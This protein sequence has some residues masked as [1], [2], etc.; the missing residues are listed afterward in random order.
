MKKTL[1]F[2]LVM[3]MGMMAMSPATAWAEDVATLNVSGHTVSYD[4]LVNAVHAASIESNAEN[5]AT[6]TVLADVSSTEN[7]QYFLQVPSGVVTLD[8]NGHTLSMTSNQSVLAVTGGDLTIVDN[9]ANKT[10]KL[11][12]NY[13]AL[14]F[15]MGKLTVCGG[16][17]EGNY[18]LSAATWGIP[19]PG[20]IALRGGTFIKGQYES[21]IQVPYFTSSHWEILDM[22][23]CK[24]VDANTGEDV[25][26]NEDASTV[27]QSVKVVRQTPTGVSDINAVNASKAVKTIE[28]GQLV[29]TKDGKRYNAAGQLM[30]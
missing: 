27:S 6:V 26:I 3:A 30:K 12:G 17:Y 8:L 18:S 9:S 2:S 10:G 28:N 14:D 7:G 13:C 4:N 24:F 1:K 20:A 29:I 21:S 23:G 25:V 16:T 15:Q 19:K 22:E 11:Y 5:P